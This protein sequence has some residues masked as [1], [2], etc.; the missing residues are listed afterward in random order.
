VND[1]ISKVPGISKD[2]RKKYLS[3]RPI[4]E[5]ISLLIV[6]DKIVSPA[7]KRHRYEELKN[8]VNERIPKHAEYYKNQQLLTG[9]YNFIKKVVD[10]FN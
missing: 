3:V 10:F 6:Y 1:F 9:A 2:V 4:F 7:L 5:F 8:L